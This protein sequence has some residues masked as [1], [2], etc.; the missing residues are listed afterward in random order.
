MLIKEMFVKPIDRELRGVIKVGQNDAIGQE[1]EEYVVTKELKKYFST[2]FEAY[3][4]GISH[5]T[6]EMAV[7]ISGFFGSGKSHFLKILAYLLENREVNGKRA[8]DYF[9]DDKKITD[10]TI[11][12]N[13]E[14]ACR[15]STDVIL[16]NIDSLGNASGKEKEPILPIFRRAFDE[17][18][19]FCGRYPH[20]ADLERML[21]ENGKYGE[22]KRFFEE[23]HGASWEESREDLFFI[24]D[25][26]VSALAETG[27]MREDEARSWY[28]NK[29]LTD[30]S[31]S[32]R[33]FAKLLRRYLAGK[34]DSHQIVFL[35]DE[36]GQYI[37]EDSGLMLNLQTLVEDI[38]V[39]CGSRVWVIV[40]SQQNIDD[41]TRVRGDDFSKIQGRF[42]T[43]LSLSSSNVG[44]VIQKR[45]LRK[46]KTAEDVL[47]ALYENKQTIL[48]NLI[49]FRNDA[50]LKI[51]EDAANFSALYPFIPYQVNLTQKAL[52]A[53][54]QFSSSGKHLSD[55][56]RSMLS[57]FQF[58]AAAI[59]NQS[60]GRFVPL[61]LFY[62][63]L[64][65]NLDHNYRMVIDH[66]EENSH[67]NPNGES[68]CFAVNL[69]KTLFLVKNVNDFDPSLENIVTLMVS[70]IDD[71]RGRLTARVREALEKLVKEALVLKHNGKYV[72][73]T[74]QEQE[75]TR[76][77]RNTTVSPSEITEEL[78]KVIFSEDKLYPVGKFRYSAQNSFPFQRSI[79][80]NLLDK[81]G[82]IG[83]NILTPNYPKK[84]EL[85]RTMGENILYVVLPQDDQRFLDELEYSLKIEKFLKQ[86]ANDP[87][88]DPKIRDAKTR[89]KRE[90]YEN[91]LPL[92]KTALME[93]K[94]YSNGGEIVVGGNSVEDRLNDA[95][96]VL[97]DRV[98]I[99]LSYITDAKSEN[100]VKALL[101]AR[102]DRK[103]LGDYSEL[104]NPVALDE[105]RRYID[106]NT[107]DCV[108]LSLKDIL[109]KFSKPPFG[110][111]AGDI[112]WLVAQLF[113]L[114]EIELSLNGE[115]LIPSPGNAETNYTYLTK[116]SYR[117]SLKVRRSEK[118][119][120]GQ[121]TALQNI[122]KNLFD[123]ML[124]DSDDYTLKQNFQEKLTALKE[125]LSAS[126]RRIE[127]HPRYPG[128]ETMEAGLKAANDILECK[129]PKEFFAKL[130]ELEQS[131]TDF[132]EDY[133]EVKHFFDKDSKQPA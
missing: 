66:A 114:G 42:K 39:E 16:F 81:I 125:E 22:F 121:R 43:R 89:E 26:L 21:T 127:R 24:A 57:L 109:L 28:D 6:D 20:V 76:R 18:L 132:A 123:Q 48:K 69:L 88:A 37:G 107:S 93:A 38:G 11:L 126:L 122:A 113:V 25:S 102:R 52:T 101:R 100:D 45:L 62:N 75:A 53:I 130:V 85:M 35:V 67:L 34:G 105:M 87:K 115:V 9:R 98:F 56:E 92:L 49:N 14:L 15:P 58:S 86:T 40:T 78:H 44:E 46:T 8:I 77:I 117:E 73:Q 32:P 104:P 131:L 19:G 5:R 106:G 63:A 59:M 29:A 84:F 99:N 91:A 30:Y 96:R 94:I 80:D 27:M 95:M 1:L 23:K 7:W 116:Q 54:R 68:D 55:G 112:E 82:D 41:I 124:P 13:M 61:Y 17:K 70:G 90:R 129:T 2:F 111:T 83:L 128:K 108:K 12:G 31:A 64:E 74:N 10:Q 118:S 133:D 110:Y 36:V 97:V 119:S 4:E 47:T 51:F 79:D 71:D 3:A 65:N 120:V 33:D 50:E 103:M 60:E 72:F